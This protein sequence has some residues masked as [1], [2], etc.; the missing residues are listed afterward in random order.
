M[1]FLFSFFYQST[2]FTSHAVNGHEMYFG[3][4]VLGK[5]STIGREILPTPSL[6]FTVGQKVRDLA[7]FKTSLNFA[8]VWKCSKIS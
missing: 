5:A 4:S 1:N 7:S 2:V 3:G 8:R 6:V